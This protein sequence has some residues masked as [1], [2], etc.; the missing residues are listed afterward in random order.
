VQS[1]RAGNGPSE[2]HR[3]PDGAKRAKKAGWLDKVKRKYV[4]V[5]AKQ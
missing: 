2:V 5:D 3:E 4:I 1:D